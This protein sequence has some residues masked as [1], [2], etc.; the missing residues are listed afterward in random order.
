MELN[1]IVS[2]HILISNIANK[3]RNYYMDIFCDQIPA[4]NIKF[5]HRSDKLQYKSNSCRVVRN[6]PPPSNYPPV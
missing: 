4:N 6:V 5:E 3:K 1:K 2:K